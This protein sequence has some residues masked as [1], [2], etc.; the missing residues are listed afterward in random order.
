M[1]NLFIVLVVGCLLAVMLFAPKPEKDKTTEVQKPAPLVPISVEESKLAPTVHQVSPL[2]RRAESL[3]ELVV[4]L[5]RKVQVPPAKE[6]QVLAS[7]QDQP[8]KLEYEIFEPDMFLSEI[9]P[10]QV[11]QLA[12]VLPG[13]VGK[14][15]VNSGQSV[16]KETLLIEQLHDTEDASV[17]AKEMELAAARQLATDNSKILSADEST[18]FHG[19]E[20][21][22]SAKLYELRAA[23]ESEVAAKLHQRKQSEFALKN[24]VVTFEAT[25]TQVQKIEKDLEFERAKLNQRKLFAPYDGIVGEVKVGTGSVVDHQRIL[26]EFYDV[27][28]V[29][30]MISLDQK[31][32]DANP[33]CLTSDSVPILVVE[34]QKIE[35]AL[36]FFSPVIEEGLRLLEIHFDNKETSSG[37][38]IV[39]GKNYPFYFENRKQTNSGSIAANRK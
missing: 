29:K 19:S 30:L 2:P 10:I 32:E 39:P 8:S 16:A 22:K 9:K 13:P 15:H 34:G 28:K 26:C 36:K 12:F 24:A 20:L 6:V 21:K 33:W 11:S 35:G 37:W 17:A 25:N 27:K 23:S 38:L 4:R 1:K 5:Q 31:E 7:K 18:K 14:I 3:E